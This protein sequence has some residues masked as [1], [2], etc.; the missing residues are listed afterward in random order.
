[1]CIHLK[2]ELSRGFGT[3]FIVFSRLTQRQ[4]TD[5]DWDLPFLYRSVDI[6]NSKAFPEFQSN[7]TRQEF[8]YKISRL[9][10]QTNA[11]PN[12]YYI[13]RLLSPSISVSDLDKHHI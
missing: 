8:Q 7:I 13:I 4:I 3:P 1:M 6:L 10:R 11:D 9:I 12:I 2:I 5:L